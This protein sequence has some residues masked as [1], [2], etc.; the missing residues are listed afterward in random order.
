[1]WARCTRPPVSP[2]RM[3]F[4]APLISSAAEGIPLRPSRAEISPSCIAPPRASER[5]SQWSATAIPKVCAYSS[6][7]R[8]RRLEATGFPSSLTATA[9]ASTSSPNSVS[10]SPFWPI[11]TAAIGET[12]AF[13]ARAA[14]RSTKPTVAWLSVTG[15]VL[16]IAQTAV[17]PPAAAAIAPVAIVSAC[18]KPGSRRCTWMSMSPG[19]TTL[20]AA[21]MTLAPGW[22]GMFRPT[23]SIRPSRMRT[24]ARSS[25]PRGGSITRPPRIS[26]SVIAPARAGGGGGAPV[27]RPAGEEVEHRHPHGDAVG[28]LGKD[29]AVGAVGDVAV[30]LD[31]AVHRAGMENHQILGR[32]LQ[33]LPGD[34]EHPVVLTDR[35]NEPRL[36][37]L[38][39]EPE[40][41]ERVGPGDRLLDPRQDPDAELGEFARDQGGR[42]A[43]R[44]FGA[45]LEEAPDVAPG[46]PAVQ[47]V[48]AERDLESLDPPEAV[49]QRQQVEQPLGG[50]LVHPVAG[51]D[52]VGADPLPQEL[53]RA[54]RAV[55]DHDH[56]DPHRLEI[57]GG[58][59]QGL[60]IG[61]RGAASGD[62]DG[63]G[64]QA[65]LG[66]LE[67]DPGPGGGL[68]EEIDD[69]L[70]A[71]RRHLLDGALADF[72]ER[73]GGVED[74]P[75][76]PGGERL[77]AD[78]ILP[79]A[80][81]GHTG[82]PRT[83]STWSRPSSSRTATSTR[84]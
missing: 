6:A 40:H 48:A 10:C 20:P 63:V 60:A 58:V 61:H 3:M 68:E 8:M 76:L 84:I 38:E 53:R 13:P 16:G 49:A 1:M 45:E 81:A 35:G 79:E 23:A 83:S 75:D 11:D 62:V 32:P 67:R 65:L 5:S 51:V 24:S 22:A 69:G 39:L 34:A 44:H 77:E 36:H 37:P 30:D 4:L 70:A 9:P 47:H 46:H 50:V 73:L 66:E 74:E 59:H 80:G 42:A 14:W 64:A 26:R 55:A 29:D 27:G 17:N 21:S 18:S 12:R 56:V 7:V 78:Q 33:P 52:D 43:D 82:A 28:H 57:A 54:A 31:A 15:S 25:L 71:E 41:V 2:A 19:A 72:L